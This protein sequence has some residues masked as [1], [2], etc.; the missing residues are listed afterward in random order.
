MTEMQL[1]NSPLIKMQGITKVF[2]SGAGE[3]TALDNIN[4]E[5]FP[6]EFVGIVGKSGSGKSTL[7]NMITGI[8]HPSKGNIDIETGNAG[9]AG[10]AHCRQIGQIGQA[11][12]AGHRIDPNAVSAHG[13]NGGAGL[14]AHQI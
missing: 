12:V 2:K 8:D 1:N 11:A 3:F 13:G 6:G 4:L 7:A 9:N 5:F 14:F 10:F